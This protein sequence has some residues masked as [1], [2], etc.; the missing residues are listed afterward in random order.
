MEAVNAGT[1]ITE[2]SDTL[3]KDTGVVVKIQCKT[4]DVDNISSGGRDSGRCYCR[5]GDLP[6]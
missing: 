5:Y 4:E 3:G 1:Y 6:A 2:A